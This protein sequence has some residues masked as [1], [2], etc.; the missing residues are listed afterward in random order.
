MLPRT[1]DEA[2]A[3]PAPDRERW[4]ALA[5]AELGGGPVERRLGART[6]EGI[7][8]QPVYTRADVPV[9]DSS[10]FSGL[11]PMT[12]GSRPLGTA[13]SGWDLRQERGEAD[14][15][16]AHGAIREDLDGGVTSVVV[17]LDACARA[18]L[19]PRDARGV[20]LVGRNGIAAYTLDDLDR[21]LDGVHLDM[22]GVSLEA[23]GAFLPGA[24][25]LAALWTRRGVA[26]GAAAGRFQADPL[27]VLAR[28]GELPYALEEGLG[29]VAELA[30]W[31]AARYPRVRAVRVGT[32]PYHHAGCT[33]AQDLAFS[34][35]TGIEYLR[36]MTGR[37]MSVED[38]CGQIEFSYA[39]GCGMFLAIAKLRGARRLWARVVEASGGSVN[40]RRMTMFVRPSKRV[41]TTRDHWVNML[42]NT[43]CVFAAGVGGADAIGSVPFDATL[44]EPSPAARRLA[45]NTHHLLMA[46][47]RVH[48]VCDL[49]GGSWYLERLTD[50]L[51]ERAWT[52]LQSVESRGGMARALLD[53]WVAEQVEA[54]AE[55]RTR[56]I[57]T[58]KDVIVG[59]SE[60]PDVSSAAPHEPEPDRASLA[61]A[62]RA[63][64]ETRGALPDIGAGRMTRIDRLVAL[65]ASGATIGELHA[66][67][68]AA[69]RG[70]AAH[71][72]AV[73]VHAFAEPFEHLRDAA[74]QWCAE[75]GTRPR[76]FLALLG[77]PA[78]RQAREHYCRNLLAAGGFEVVAGDLDGAPGKA[79]ESLRAS[80]AAVALLAGPDPRYADGIG[81][82]A[83][84]LHDAGARRVV[85]AGNPGANEEAYR[86]AGIDEF[87]FVRCDV[88]ALLRSWL[89]ASGVPV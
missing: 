33:A 15:V 26:A 80:G 28:D 37:G 55:P 84:A 85:L 79:L 6:Y 52:I 3:F 13:L 16:R 14:P 70:P 46:E 62:A 9:D 82:A 11:P 22:I 45:R 18:G 69:G 74:D 49:A 39:V 1:L 41:L 19:D 51:C 21:L 20:P 44:G 34:M 72:R 30:S 67:A 54:S 47:S 87:V 58:R 63:R 31:A 32:A 56:N 81:H 17:R 53:G 2:D 86:A 66:G 27:G 42:R 5:E 71:A 12:R 89:G 40:A 68:G 7:A 4:R 8:L 29:G 23:G 25:L 38:A 64:L 60:F 24:A 83:R 36:A 50:E 75:C 61:N 43:A 76:A 35:A 57:A 78:D 10:G 73:H 59:V 48:G 88:V 77:A 65:A